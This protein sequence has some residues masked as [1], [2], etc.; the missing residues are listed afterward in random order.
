MLIAEGSDWFWWYGDESLVGSRPHVR[1]AVPAHVS[2]IYRAL[3]KQPRE[4]FRHTSHRKHPQWT[5]SATG[6]IAQVIRW[7]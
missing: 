4:L 6:F 5:V 2:N 1:R 3:G 7:D